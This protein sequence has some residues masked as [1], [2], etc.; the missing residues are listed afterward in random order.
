VTDDPHIAHPIADPPTPQVAPISGMPITLAETCWCPFVGMATL[1]PVSGVNQVATTR[2]LRMVHG[3][4]DAQIQQAFNCITTRCM[5][6]IADASAPTT[7]GT[8]RLITG[9]GVKA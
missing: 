8:C 3:A 9:A 4:T 6:W 5:S 2:G 1:P 7:H